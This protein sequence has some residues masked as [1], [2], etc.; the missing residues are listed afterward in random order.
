M[1]ATNQVAE[2]EDVKKRFKRL[3]YV[4]LDMSLREGAELTRIKY[5]TLRRAMTLPRYVPS[6]KTLEK[7]K[8]FVETHE[9]AG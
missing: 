5:D 6:D 3:L 4:T 8:A 9:L 2:F 1:N 7:L